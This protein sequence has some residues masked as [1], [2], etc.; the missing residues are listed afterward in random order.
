M[1]LRQIPEGVHG[2]FL[3]A[4]AL[5]DADAGEVLMHEGVQVGGFLPVDLPPFM[6]MG[7]DV[8]DPG[9]H[10][11]KAHKGRGREPDVLDEHDH[12][13]RADGDEIRDQ[14]GDA[15]GEHIL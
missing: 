9:G 11:R 14:G 8:P 3:R 2:L 4:E 10:Q 15:V 5:D 6:G 1:L 12:G 13:H 7:L